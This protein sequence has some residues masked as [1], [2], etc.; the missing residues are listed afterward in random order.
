M[1]MFSDF[2]VSFNSIQ[3]VY[4]LHGNKMFQNFCPPFLLFN[5]ILSAISASQPLA[6]AIS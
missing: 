4:N 5:N 1:L 6:Q 2:S 3:S